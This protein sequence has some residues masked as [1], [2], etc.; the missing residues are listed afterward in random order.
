MFEEFNLARVKD[1]TTRGIPPRPRLLLLSVGERLK[2]FDEATRRQRRR[3]AGRKYLQQ[4]SDRGWKRE[5]LYDRA[6]PR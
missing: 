1:M 3:Q 5:E 6:R 4:P 2:L